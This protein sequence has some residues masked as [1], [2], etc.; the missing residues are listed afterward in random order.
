MFTPMLLNLQ[1]GLVGEDTWEHIKSLK[2]PLDNTRFY[3]GTVDFPLK[4]ERIWLTDILL[5][6]SKDLR[7]ITSFFQELKQEC[8]E[9][10]RGTCLFEFRTKK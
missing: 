8:V 3:V 9:K 2:T 4:A 1:Y 7:K 10:P 6:K 5:F